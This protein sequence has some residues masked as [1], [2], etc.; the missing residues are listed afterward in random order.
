MQPERWERLKELFQAT[1]DQP[2][3]LR[4]GFLAGA[5][6]D[7]EPLRAEVA[8]LLRANDAADSS[9]G[10]PPLDALAEALAET[11]APPPIG[12]SGDLPGERVEGFRLLR[13]I[14]AGGMGV[15]FEAEQER[16]RRRVALKVL[17]GVPAGD[18]RR[19]LFEREVEALARLRHPDIAAIYHSGQTEQG[20][21][22]FAME[23]AQGTTLGDAL[24]GEGPA[25]PLLR[26]LR[27]RLRLFVRICAAVN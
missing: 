17:R 15:V 12:F 5:C 25:A 10:P 27:E 22:Y 9:F 16:P 3:E 7:D 8:E 23:L 13:H 11:D 26:D 14:G 1:L 21:P 6:A 19:R 4:A 20:E 24:R 18:Q 2:E